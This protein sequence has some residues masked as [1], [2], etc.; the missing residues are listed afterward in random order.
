MIRNLIFA[1]LGLIGIQAVIWPWL[2]RVMVRLSA[3]PRFFLVYPYDQRLLNDVRLFFVEVREQLNPL[4]FEP[5][6]YLMTNEMMSKNKLC[7]FVLENRQEQDLVAAISLVSVA[8]DK[9]RA[10]AFYVE[11]STEFEDGTEINT[12]NSTDPGSMPETSCIRLWKIHGM[13]D[14]AKLYQVH[15]CRLEPLADAQKL[16][17]PQTLDSVKK[18]QAS[19]MRQLDALVKAG[20]FKAVDGGKRYG[21]RWPSAI[22]LGWKEIWPFKSL[23]RRQLR[24]AARRRLRE[25]SLPEKYEEIDYKKWIQEQPSYLVK[26]PMPDGYPPVDSGRPPPAIFD[27]PACEKTVTSYDASDTQVLCPICKEVVTVP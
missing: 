19:T 21:L 1:I 23:R 5:V 6:A 10:L 9:H 12:N 25:L 8:G 22:R 15:K 17:L 13:R 27:C 24:S 3:N 2:M 18:N 7:L 4:G 14:M 20:W 11:F 16:D 26:L